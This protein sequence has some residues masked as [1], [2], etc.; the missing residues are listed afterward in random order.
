MTTEK[1]EELE[2]MLCK[3]IEKIVDKGELTAGTLET[4]DKLMHT[5][6]NTY[7]VHMGED[8]AYSQAGGNSYAGNSYAGNSYARGGNSYRNSYANSYARG[9]GRYSYAADPKEEMLD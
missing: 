6:K 2:K 5:L 9:R 7:K 4:I 1:Y 3:E 8:G